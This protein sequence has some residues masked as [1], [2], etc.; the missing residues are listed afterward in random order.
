M[1]WYSGIISGVKAV[2]GVVT[3]DKGADNVMEVAR[4]VG[5]WIDE[6]TLTEEE[7][8][9]VIADDYAVVAVLDLILFHYLAVPA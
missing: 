2:F 4:G 7:K 9:G 1:S 5:T 8:M 3:T 6:R